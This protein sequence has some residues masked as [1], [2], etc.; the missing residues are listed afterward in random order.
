MESLDA[1]ILVQWNGTRSICLQCVQLRALSEEPVNRNEI[2]FFLT[3]LYREC[4][5]S[6]LSHNLLLAAL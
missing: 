5:A 6:R 1:H 4:F 3:L 2:F